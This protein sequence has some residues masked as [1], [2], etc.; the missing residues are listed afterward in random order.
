V[1][2]AIILSIILLFVFS[3]V[4]IAEIK[5]FIKEYSYQASEL[6]SKNTCRAIA[7][8]Q[9]KRELLEELGTYVESRT[10]VKDNQVDKDEITTLA[11]GV[12]QLAVLDEKWNGKEYWLKAE[13]K[14]DPYDVAASI[15]KL[16]NDEQLVHDLEEARAEAEQATE[17][18]EALRNQL[19][20]AMA[21]QQK[22]EQYNEA[23]KQLVVS[24]YFERG[25]AYTVAGNYE[26]AGRVYDQVIQLEPVYVKAYVNRSII[27]IQLG[28]Y[29]K[30]ADDLNTAAA[31]SPAME[32][33]F[34]K[35]IEIKKRM[36]EISI[37]RTKQSGSSIQERMSADPL[38]RLL[39]SKKKK[40]ASS[41]VPE[42]Q[43]FSHSDSPRKITTGKNNIGK[44]TSQHT[45]EGKAERRNQDLRKQRDLR[46][47]Q[48]IEEIRKNKA[49]KNK[50]KKVREKEA[51]TN[52][53]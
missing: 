34:Y 45:L 21:D 19:A 46:R 18:A 8:E 12:V 11:A 36:K 40:S 2:K 6:D 28:R 9:L 25:S 43:T 15:S 42:K 39:D 52:K 32:D 7:T 44:D 38:Q 31:L 3:S 22:Q 33:A 17:E 35:R 49:A 5:T 48:R 51:D 10:V 13:V 23:V 26:E 37:A 41:H 47:K 30:A 53:R 16:K 24:D 29:G 4:L 50:K 20:K 14:A 1:K 27:Y